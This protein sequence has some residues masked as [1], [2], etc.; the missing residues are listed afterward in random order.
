MV[1]TLS[2]STGIFSLV[3]QSLS[4]IFLKIHIVHVIFNLS[5]LLNKVSVLCV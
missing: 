1:F 3:K 5:S 4:S 2:F